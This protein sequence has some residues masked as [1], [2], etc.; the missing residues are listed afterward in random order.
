[1][2][3]NVA[4]ISG[5]ARIS[6][7]KTVGVFRNQ[8]PEV[9]AA[10]A[11]TCGLDAVQ[12]HGGDADLV[13]LRSSLPQGCEIWTTCGVGAIAE[14]MREGANRT[15][16]DTQLNGRSGGTGQSF[17]WT[18]IAERPDLSGAILA[19]GIGPAN[20]RA[21]QQVGTFGIDIGSAV[22]SEPGRK[23]LDQLVAVFDALRPKCR[24]T[25]ACG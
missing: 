4:A 16:F 12:L 8:G 23:D 10:A 1:V 6:G 20:A 14:P 13:R 19:G 21:A 11:D 22:E 18:L 7:V 2:D 5:H 15:L 24:G 9:V 17:D 3:G 25:V